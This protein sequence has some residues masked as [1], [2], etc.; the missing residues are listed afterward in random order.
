MPIRPRPITPPWSPRSIGDCSPSSAASSG[1]GSGAVGADHA[2]ADLACQAMA[3]L[4]QEATR[5]GELVTLLRHD[6]HGEFLTGE[7]CAGK[8]EVLEFFAVVHVEHGGRGVIATS[9][10]LLERFVGDV[11]GFLLAGCI[12]IS[13]HLCPFESSAGVTTTW[14]VRSL[15]PSANGIKL[16]P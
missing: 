7:V 4:N 3:V 6:P 10:Q 2:L 9:G 15:F 8:F 5:T 16:S 12:V 14:T 1:S 11:I 13:S